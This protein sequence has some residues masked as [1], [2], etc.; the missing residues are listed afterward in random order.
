MTW[1]GARLLSPPISVQE[2]NHVTVGTLICNAVLS[3]LGFLVL[4][5]RYNRKLNCNQ[6]CHHQA[7]GVFPAPVR[8][9]CAQVWLVPTSVR[10]L[11]T[12][13]RATAA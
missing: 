11:R 12:L 8:A 2:C 9:A 4:T 13:E 1:A 10:A 6:S 7:P 5:P 3:E